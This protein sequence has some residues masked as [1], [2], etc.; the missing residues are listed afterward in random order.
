MWLPAVITFVGFVTGLSPLEPGGPCRIEHYGGREGLL[1]RMEEHV[2]DARGRATESVVRQGSRLDV[3]ERTNRRFDRGSRL[4][5]ET[6][7]RWLVE[8][9]RWEKEVVRHRWDAA[10]REVAEE[11]RTGSGP[12]AILRHEYDAQGRRVTTIAL[13][14]RRPP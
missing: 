8:Q 7:R 2:R 12:T 11:R 5:L 9:R 10:G 13:A 3:L 14:G 4:S 1:V 6:T